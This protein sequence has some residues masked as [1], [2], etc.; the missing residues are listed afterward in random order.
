MN[1]KEGE[2]RVIILAEFVNNV[3]YQNVKGD[4]NLQSAPK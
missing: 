3:T 2:K 1:R 4:K